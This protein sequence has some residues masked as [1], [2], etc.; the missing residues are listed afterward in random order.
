MSLF[1]SQALRRQKHQDPG[2]VLETA[3]SAVAREADLLPWGEFSEWCA[4][5]SPREA[6]SLSS[7]DHK[8][9]LSFAQ[10]L[11]TLCV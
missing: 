1:M 5:P 4:L 8:E 11:V 3:A 2:Q 9:K 7:P 10:F 6:V